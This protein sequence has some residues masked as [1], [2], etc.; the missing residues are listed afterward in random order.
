MCSVGVF[1]FRKGKNEGSICALVSGVIL[2]FVPFF[3]ENLTILIVTMVI[4]LAAPR[5]IKV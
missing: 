3:V 2:F 1:Y 5:Y 4:F